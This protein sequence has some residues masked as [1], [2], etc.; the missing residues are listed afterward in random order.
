MDNPQ[1][2]RDKRY[3]VQLPLVVRWG[4]KRVECLTDDVSYRG[5]FV[6]MDDP[7][8]VRELL[9]I[10][11]N[12]PPEDVPF[13]SHGMA[14]WVQRPQE[15]GDHAPGVGVQFYAMGAER[16]KWELF[17]NHVRK[18]AEVVPDSRDDLP[19]PVNRKYPRHDLRLAV[20]PRTFN[21]LMI[22]YTRDVS[23]G[24]MF[25]ATNRSFE[26]D[27]ELQLDVQHPEADETFSIAAVVR[28]VSTGERP[29][30]GVEF[31]E[32]GDPE[33]QAFYEFIHVHIPSLDDADLIDP[34]D[35]NLE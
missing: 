21:E 18:S 10:E 8:R 1:R 27:T 13:S 24:G 17:I 19:D 5:M 33:R 32:L 22:F 3:H 34:D 31:H 4:G 16:P 35:P 14:V 28:R 23:R 20:R 30:I 6:R 9:Q 15:A 2:R 12:L 11:A 7:P 26:V 29:G 25:L